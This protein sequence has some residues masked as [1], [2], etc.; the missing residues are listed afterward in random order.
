MIER[1]V[2]TNDPE[3]S[4][5]ALEAVAPKISGLQRR[6]VAILQRSGNYGATPWELMCETGVIYNTVWRRLSE[7]KKM[8]AVVNTHLRRP[9]NRGFNETVVILKTVHDETRQYAL[10]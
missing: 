4:Y 2:R 1:N 8:E 10:L 5:E 7:L 3:T 6:I 9:N